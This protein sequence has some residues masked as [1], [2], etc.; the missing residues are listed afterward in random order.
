ML[1]F[2]LALLNEVVDKLRFNDLY[3]KYKTDVMQF[4]TSL[5]KNHHDAED[6]SQE[7]WLVIAR[8]FDALRLEDDAS[9]KAFLMRVVKYKSIDMIR[10]RER[11][12]MSDL[13]SLLDMPH[14]DYDAVL[15]AIC[16][17]ETEETIC[18]CIYSL[19]EI[20]RDVLNLYYL[21]QSSAKEIAGFLSM[22][23][24]TV[25]KRLERGR[26]MLIRLLQERGEGIEK[27][28]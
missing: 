18:R 25:R 10:K 24:R 16:Q 2:Y 8:R 22:D 11:V 23:V 4:A 28:I 20:Y 15:F 27:P 5:V 14:T 3:E 26:L 13:D 7:A 17:R 21:N 12:D 9:I 1:T 19:G 6:I